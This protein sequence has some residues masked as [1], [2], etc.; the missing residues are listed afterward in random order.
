MKLHS[1]KDIV[2]KKYLVWI[3]LPGVLAVFCTGVL[4]AYEL[5]LDFRTTS[6][7]LSGAVSQAVSAYVEDSLRH[8][9]VFSERVQDHSEQSIQ[10]QMHDLFELYP[11]FDR[12][13]WLDE[14]GRAL[15]AYPPGGEGMTFPVLLERVDEREE[16][17]SRPIPS[18][19]SGR[20]VVYMGHMREGGATLVGE[21]DLQA[22][23]NH[24]LSLAPTGYRVIVADRYGNLIMHP[25]NTLVEQ[26]E[27]IG[28][29]GLFQHPGRT[30]LL[31]AFYREGE[32]IFVGF[33]DTVGN[34]GTVLIVSRPLSDLTLPAM[35]TMGLLLGALILLTGLILFRFQFDLDRL[36]LVHLSA[37]VENIRTV[38][39]GK[40]RQPL[41][42]L[43]SFSE[44]DEVEGEFAKMIEVIHRREQA[45]VESTRRHRAMFEESAAVQLLLDTK[46]G[47]IVD[48]NE[49]AAGYYGY[50]RKQLIG[51]HRDEITAE[52]PGVLQ[53]YIHDIRQNKRHLIRSRHK[54]SNGEI[55]DVDIFG[56]VLLLSD[57]EAFFLIVQDVTE[58]TRVE[59]E[60]VR[61]KEEAEQANS[62]KT[63]FLANMSHELRTPLSGVI[64]MSRLLK[65]T[66][67]TSEQTVLVNMSLESAEHLLGIVAQLLELSSLSSGKVRLR[68]E[69]FEVRSGLAPALSMCAVLAGKK[70]ILCEQDIAP[71]VPEAVRADL[72]KLRQVLINLMNN[73]VKFTEQGVVMV[74]VRHVPA[75]HDMRAMLEF[76][77]RDTGIGIP[78]D[79]HEIIFESFVLGEDVLTKR[80][81]G[82]GLGLA[83]CKQLVELMGGSIRVSSTMGQGSLFTFTVPYEMPI[84]EELVTEKAI[85]VVP[86]AT[87]S[88]R[89]LVAEDERTNRLLAMRLLQKLGHEVVAVSDG[90]QVLEILEKE[91]FDVVLMDIQMPVMNGLETT[92]CIRSGEVPGVSRDVPIVALTAYARNGDSEEFLSKGM[93]GYLSKPIDQA[94]LAALLDQLSL[95]S[96]KA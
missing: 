9:R 45:I 6:R 96:A 47:R 44:L 48:A 56:S 82:T 79:K 34:N 63:L 77:V 3:V 11:H 89:V 1:F 60:L 21:L 8:L 91:S 46:T 71:D 16:M 41:Q 83:I 19:Q 12:L 30:G 10:G 81:G 52:S 39:R 28:R 88:L 74:D 70:G 76:S 49:A 36:L 25:D 86:V 4:V 33:A 80:Y 75:T 84:P 32:D 40:Y 73:A 50:P 64:G 92:R 42:R 23:R 15:V 55:R 22:L 14:K 5:L 93:D 54:L 31:D 57:G 43:G 67:L 51:M 53:A 68:L 18:V 29:I 27:N 61:A 7:I 2:R 26:Q 90:S 58:R 24:V 38:A 65:D 62:A 20:I 78:E 59:R 85:P 87:R 17:I 69:S 35:R 72:G 13:I 66:E 94:Q 95:R 37:F